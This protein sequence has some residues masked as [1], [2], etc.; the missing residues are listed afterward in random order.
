M[1]G[2]P[3]APKTRKG[4]FILMDAEGKTVL[5]TLAFQYNPDTMSRTLTPRTA[6][7]E[8]GDR[9]E[10]LR[11]IGPPTETIKIEVEIDNTDKL[12]R[13]ENNPVAVENGIG[14]ELAALETIISPA[15]A[16]L[17]AANQ[18]AQSGTLE[19]LPLPSPLLLL[20]LGT[21]RTLPVRI[22]EFAI[23]EE[24][25]DTRLN[26]IR[27]RVTLGMRALTVDDLAFGSKGAELFM[28]AARRRE[29][30]ARSTSAGV[31]ALGLGSPP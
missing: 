16:D 13:P 1:T 5:R 2:F 25:F 18:L 27:A 17:A 28:A 23:V 11:L 20:V 8:G 19:V 22:T 12:E 31:Q 7:A 14:P 9:L 10:A 6:K 29:K 21:N 3:G 4:G 15:A 26:P 24:A 30:L